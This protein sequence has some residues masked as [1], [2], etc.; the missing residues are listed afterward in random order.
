MCS[1]LAL[2][3]FTDCLPFFLSE[4]EQMGEDDMEDD[5]CLHERMADGGVDVVGLVGS[6]LAR[7]DDGRRFSPLHLT[8]A[9][10]IPP[11]TCA[12][13]ELC[14]TSQHPWTFP[15]LLRM[16]CIPSPAA[17]ES[18]AIMGAV[19]RASLSAVLSS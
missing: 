9:L 5:E 2:T 12:F 7:E 17:T 4:A 13:E 10:H 15:Y 16:T 6:L 1:Q 19:A 11:V 14:D 18:S 3:Q 8:R